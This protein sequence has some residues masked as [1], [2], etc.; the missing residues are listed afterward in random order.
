MSVCPTCGQPVGFADRGEELLSLLRR[1]G[2]VRDV[3]FS[4]PTGLWYITRLRSAG[5]YTP[6][7][8]T[9]VSQLIA[10][11][12]LV[13]TYP[14]CADCYCIPPS[15]HPPSLQQEGDSRS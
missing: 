14:E 13:K 15:R 12:K 1:D 11:G 9:V 10:R 6:F 4:P 3:Y 2:I 5:N 7:P 8:A